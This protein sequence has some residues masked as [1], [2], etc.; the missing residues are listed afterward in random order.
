MHQLILS[1]NV[2]SSLRM[3]AE[4]TKS[5]NRICRREQAMRRPNNNA[6]SFCLADRNLRYIFLSAFLSFTIPQHYL[7]FHC[8]Y[9]DKT[10]LGFVTNDTCDMAVF[11]PTLQNCQI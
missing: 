8:F 7:Y 3:H 9:D 10:W 4:K 6:L 11:K 5:D 2:Y 1:T